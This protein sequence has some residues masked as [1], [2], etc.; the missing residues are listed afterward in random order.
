MLN[1]LQPR[2]P[3]PVRGTSRPALDASVEA[4]AEWQRETGG[5]AL[6]ARR[7]AAVNR[8]AVHALAMLTLDGQT[9]KLVDAEREIDEV[10]ASA[11]DAV[12]AGL[13][14]RAGLGGADG[15]RPIP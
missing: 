8:S 10:V 5:T 13:I 3:D 11:V 14:A 12:L 1:A 6:P 7:A 15:D 2:A 4:V 9:A